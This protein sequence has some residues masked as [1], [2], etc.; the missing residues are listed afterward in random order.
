MRTLEQIIDTLVVNYDIDAL[1]DALSDAFYCTYKDY[2]MD[3]KYYPQTLESPAE[4]PEFIADGYNDYVSMIVDELVDVLSDY[5]ERDI[6]I[7]TNNISTICSAL[8]MEF[9]DEN[10]YIEKAI[11]RIG[12][13]NYF[14]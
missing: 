6:Q 7:I 4:Y 14:R 3:G 10:T 9:Y 12:V 13:D 5:D 8:D 1:S 2:H 11:E